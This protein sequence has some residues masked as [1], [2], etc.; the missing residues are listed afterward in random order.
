MVR[1]SR[2]RVAATAQSDFETLTT[3]DPHYFRTNLPIHKG[4]FVALLICAG[5]QVIQSAPDGAVAPRWSNG[6]LIGQ[7]RARS[8]GQPENLENGFKA[9]V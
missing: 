3:T 8:D 6:L 5:S 7:P 4:D 2:T 1:F 9:V